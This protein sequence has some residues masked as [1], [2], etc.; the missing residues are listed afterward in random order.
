MTTPIKE[1]CN[2]NES[3]LYHFIFSIHII[4]QNEPTISDYY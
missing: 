1:F 3:I 2:T 4:Y